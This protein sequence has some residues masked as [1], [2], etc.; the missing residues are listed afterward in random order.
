MSRIAFISILLAGV[1]SF[2]CR[3]NSSQVRATWQ[4][5]LMVQ[6]G[7]TS[8]EVFGIE[9]PPAQ[10]FAMSDGKQAVEW[11]CGKPLDYSK[12]SA[13]MRVL[14]GKDGRVEHVNREINH[15]DSRQGQLYW[16]PLLNP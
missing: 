2:G 3:T 9:P 4:K 5:Y 14:F 15:G 8:S 16:P 13:T 11:S 6:E 12:D 10:I 7:M 1:V